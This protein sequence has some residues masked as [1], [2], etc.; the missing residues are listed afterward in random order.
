MAKTK[1]RRSH[2]DRRLITVDTDIRADDMDP[3]SPNWMDMGKWESAPS[4]LPL[5]HLTGAQASGAYFDTLRCS[6]NHR[7]DFLQVQSKFTVRNAG[8]FSAS[9]ARAF[10]RASPGY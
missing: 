5:R 7:P 6:V 9:A 3:P 1:R 8:D 2:S 10:G 4:V